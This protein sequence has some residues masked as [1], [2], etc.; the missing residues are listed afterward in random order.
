M[1]N[2]TCLFSVGV[3][4]QAL[5]REL[6]VIA[7]HETHVWNGVS[8]EEADRRAVESRGR[9][10]SIGH[11]PWLQEQLQGLPIHLLEELASDY[12]AALRIFRQP[13]PPDL[14]APLVTWLGTPRA[15]SLRDPRFVTAAF[16]QNFYAS[17][18]DRRRHRRLV[19]AIMRA[20]PPQDPWQ[21]VWCLRFLDHEAVQALSNYASGF[22]ARPLCQQLL[23]VRWSRQVPVHPTCSPR[24]QAEAFNS[25]L[26]YATEPLGRT[27]TASTSSTA[28]LTRPASTRPLGNVSAKMLVRAGLR[29]SV[30]FGYV[31]RQYEPSCGCR[32][33]GETA[34]LRRPQGP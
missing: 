5:A 24:L 29:C 18:L 11:G 27:V 30:C 19:S 32:R 8:L 23:S 22:D 13:L 3:G 20:I 7:T 28:P 25:F 2:V 31:N 4:W 26:D 33:G 10:G 14:A 9:H 17:F 1:Q 12:R 34:R 6:L 15:G 21:G 16:L